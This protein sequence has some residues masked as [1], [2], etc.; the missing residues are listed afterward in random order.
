MDS[1]FLFLRRTRF[2]VLLAVFALVGA[3]IPTSAGAEEEPD[4]AQS[5]P[6]LEEVFG[7]DVTEEDLEEAAED[8]GADYVGYGEA[9]PGVDEGDKPA[10][11]YPDSIELV[12]DGGDDVAPEGAND[13]PAAP[14]VTAD[15]FDTDVDGIRAAIEGGETGL[16]IVTVRTDVEGTNFS[17]TKSDVLAALPDGIA[18]ASTDLEALP[19]FFV[20]A[21]EAT[22]DLLVDHPLVAAVEADR[23]DEVHL[24]EVGGVI[25]T[26]EMRAAGVIGNGEEGA[27]YDPGVVAVLD[28]G[29][30]YAHAAHD[31]LW[32]SCFALGA[33]GLT[34]AGDC[35]N[36]THTQ[37]GGSA[38]EECTYNAS[39]CAHG[40]HVAG[41]AAGDG[42]GSPGDIGSGA[43]LDIYA[44]QVFSNFGG[45]P[46]SWTSDQLAALNRV[47][48]DKG[49]AVP[50][51][52]TVNMSL[53]GGQFFSAA[54]CDA[55]NASRK[56]AID[57]LRGLDVLTVISAGNSGFTTSMGAPGCISSAVTVGATT[58]A[59]GFASFTNSAPWMDFWA[60]G[61]N[62][63]STWTGGG[64]A[65]DTISG[66]SMSAPAVAGALALLGTECGLFGTGDQRSMA[67]VE[68]RIEATGVELTRGATT[69]DRIDMFNATSG[70]N[71][72]DRLAGAEEYS[73]SV[74]N[75]VTDGAEFTNCSHAQEVGEPGEA[76]VWYE[77]TPTNT[78]TVTVTTNALFDSQLR[79][80]VG[81]ND[82]TLMSQLTFL[83]FNDDG[84]AGNNALITAPVNA[85]S[86]YYFQVDGFAGQN[87]DFSITWTMAAPPACAGVPATHINDTTVNTFY[88]GA[89][90]VVVGNHLA[91][92]I[93]TQGGND[94]VCGLG[95][96][97]YINGGDGVDTM[98]GNDGNDTILGGVGVRRDFLYGGPGVDSLSA[99]D[100]ND[101]VYGNA[102]NDSM[103]GGNG[104]DRMYGGP[105]NDIMRGEAGDDLMYGTT[106]NDNMLGGSGNDRVEGQGGNDTLR[107]ED[108]DDDLRGG[109]GDDVMYGGNNNDAMYG[110]PGNDEMYGD[111]GNDN[112]FGWTGSDEMRGGS[113]N[114]IIRGQSQDDILYGDSGVDTI[115]GAGGADQIN[116]G[117]GSPDNCNFGTG[118][119]VNLGGCEII[120]NL[121]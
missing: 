91:N 67:S 68:S 85:G 60:P 57:T 97:D 14:L 105:D 48:L 70:W 120:S 33:D 112:M 37:I 90:Q 44:M 21:S 84:G 98:Y 119:D 76:T 54:A 89:N 92:R 65:Y 40:T 20:P 62:V 5:T 55:A 51:I 101:L 50:D 8:D 106:G 15:T 108:G 47:I 99:Q 9:D 49:G 96:N 66:T 23:L 59:D 34:G 18:E 27:T 71:A 56:T 87:G 73:T 6:E 53:G 35:P 107:G 13:V 28:T 72:N 25:G 116:G 2:A 103:W 3:L 52:K 1:G 43:E 29:V 95:G 115:T 30:D 7:D 114:D 41:I 36:G 17:T 75:S 111:A 82:A 4:Q 94:L 64:N 11:D 104:I 77:F 88:T 19:T 74:G 38:G 86:K 117:S 102:G 69:A 100:G 78:G 79:M 31:V 16:L 42:T 58:D 121:P 10:F 22:L 63:T 46:L 80:Y 45:T 109:T 24:D 83:G 118:I 110:Q 26:D 61:V 39:Q 32:A 81:P 93:F 113:G 12:G